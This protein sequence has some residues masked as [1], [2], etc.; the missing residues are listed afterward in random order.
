MLDYEAELKKFELAPELE[1]VKQELYDIQIEDVTD[2]MQRMMEE[3][4]EK[5]FGDDML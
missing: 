1:E 4:R 2:V 5:D 3:S